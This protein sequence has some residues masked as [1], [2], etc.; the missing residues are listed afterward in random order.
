LCEF[1]SCGAVFRATLRRLLASWAIEFGR[2]TVYS[3][4]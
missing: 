4:T 3:V 2:M 1:V